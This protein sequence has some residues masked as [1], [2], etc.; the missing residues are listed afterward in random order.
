MTSATGI[1]K[2]ERFLRHRAPAGHPENGAR[3]EA[4]YAML[5][6]PGLAGRTVPIAPRPAADPELHWVHSEEYVARL[7]ATAGKA[8]RWIGPDTFAAE[9]SYDTARLAAG[10]VMEAVAR[11][12]AGDVRHAFSLSRP[13][14]HHAERSRASGYC[15]FNNV[16][17][18]ARFSQWQAGLKRVLIVDWDVHHG[19][20]TQHIFERDSSV[21]FFSLH[22]WPHYPGTGLFTEA[23]NG[24]GEGFTVNVPLRK[25]CGDAEF[26]WVFE[27]LLKP[28]ALEFAPEIILVSAGFDALRLDPLGGMRL[29]PRGFAG[30]T[31]CLMDL[32]EELCGGRLVLSLEGGYRPA[33]LSGAVKAVLLELADA[34][35]S[36]VAQTAAGA[37][38]KTARQVLKRVT[39]VQRR[40]WRCFAEPASARAAI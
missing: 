23:G 36:E 20:G 32:A 10:G 13:P 6:E 29:T 17:L 35:R 12:V 25:R 5:K 33:A 26:A 8:A 40:F 7:A 34:T 19:N 2:D 11:V 3:L 28:L 37:D 30:L 14:G 18:A 21:L 39:Q 27:A 16:A 24:P 4:V 22:Q 1:V 9:D 15:L 38:P 31:R